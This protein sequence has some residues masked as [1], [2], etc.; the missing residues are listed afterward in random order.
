M[1]KAI[2]WTYR[3]LYDGD[4]TCYVVVVVV[5]GSADEWRVRV[6]MSNKQKPE[7]TSLQIIMHYIDTRNRPQQYIPV[8]VYGMDFIS[9]HNQ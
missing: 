7:V 6:K 4:G 2:N 1:N 3:F 5:V 8:H 9:E